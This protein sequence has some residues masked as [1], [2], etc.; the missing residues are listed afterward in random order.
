MPTRYNKFN[1]AG[2]RIDG[3]FHHLYKKM[4]VLLFTGL[5]N[6]IVIDI[7]NQLYP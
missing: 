4:Y 2:K 6:N 7:I 3:N 1:L 5:V